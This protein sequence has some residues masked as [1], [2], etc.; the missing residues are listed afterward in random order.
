MK[1]VMSNLNHIEISANEKIKVFLTKSYIPK[2]TNIVFGNRS[3][4]QA[5]STSI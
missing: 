4:A 1:T 2:T 3:Y 5:L